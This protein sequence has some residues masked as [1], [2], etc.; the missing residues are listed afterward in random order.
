MRL[1]GYLVVSA[2]LLLATACTETGETISNVGVQDANGPDDLLG[3]SDADAMTAKLDTV[4]ALSEEQASQPEVTAAEV[5]DVVEPLID[6]FETA[7]EVDPPPDLQ[8]ETTAPACVED[9]DCDDG[10]SCTTDSCKSGNCFNTKADNT[11]CGGSWDCDDYNACTLDICVAEKCAAVFFTGGDCQCDTYFDCD[12]G[13][14]CTMNYCLDGFCI[15]EPDPAA[16]GCCTQD[17]QCDDG[18]PNTTDACLQLTCSNLPMSACL[19][20]SQCD[21]EDPCTADAC[22]CSVDDCAPGE[23]LCHHAP[24]DNC[25][26]LEGQCDDGSS[27]TL[28]G[29]YDS[30]CIHTFDDK[31]VS[32]DDLP[33][34]DDGNT[35]T[36][37]EC[38]GDHCSF[39]VAQAENCCL[40]DGDCADGL[41]CTDDICQQLQCQ[42]PPVVGDAV[43]MQWGL[44]DDLDGFQVIDDGSNVKW[45]LAGG[46]FI[47]GPTALYFGDPSGPTIDNG[48]TVKGTITSPAVLLPAGKAVTLKGWTYIHCEPLFSR[49]QV[50]ISVIHDDGEIEVWNKEAVGG[51]TG[52]SWD[53]F[54]VDLSAYAGQ[55][56]QLRFAFDSIDEMLNDYEGV[57]FD[58]LRFLWPC[59]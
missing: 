21:D 59:E 4:E 53:E 38:L 29:C 44:N 10:I 26:V 6:A 43:Q 45:Q 46:K 58:D 8:E 32:C 40:L 17:S 25:C 27:Q 48:K 18:L 30:L 49:D 54:E 34:C 35:C 51:T 14:G 9:G 52:Y 55:S 50:G 56:V 39:S 11:C 24:V 36:A 42:H 20:D 57:Y 7:D 2:G 37:G 23:A 16:S 22:L 41:P 13:L 31:F 33:G 12:D 47:S 28:D 5:V 1:W 15:Y 19:D 3:I